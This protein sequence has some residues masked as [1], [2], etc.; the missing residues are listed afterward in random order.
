M[1]MPDKKLTLATGK[2][3]RVEDTTRARTVSNALCPSSLIEAIL[4][5]T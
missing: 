3:R 4:G 1:N 2:G 5:T